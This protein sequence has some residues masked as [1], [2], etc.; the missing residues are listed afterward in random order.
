MHLH[1]SG[2][3]EWVY[4]HLVN[5]QAAGSST[6][7]ACVSCRSIS[8]RGRGR[9]RGTGTVRSPSP[10]PRASGS[11]SPPPASVSPSPRPSDHSPSRRRSRSPS[12]PPLEFIPSNQGGKKLCFDG[13]M[14][15]K[16]AT[17]KATIQ[18]QC[19]RR[20]GLHC[21]GLLTTTLEV[22]YIVD[23]SSKSAI[24]P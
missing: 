7:W 19:S 1:C 23:S 22:C 21:P 12:P 16:K 24:C 17:R 8:K 15:T 5:Q 11:P 10:Q 2:L 18:W 4:R 14:Y 3:G 6:I 13:H 9:G 20:K